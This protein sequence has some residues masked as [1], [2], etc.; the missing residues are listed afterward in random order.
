MP[1]GLLRQARALSRTCRTTMIENA[2]SPTPRRSR[3]TAT[4]WR[5]RP[6]SSVG[7]R[8]TL[9]LQEGARRSDA[10]RAA[11]RFVL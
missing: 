4:A 2:D 6:R 3:T 10:R 9:E 11:R 7:E 5:R 1:K 8:P